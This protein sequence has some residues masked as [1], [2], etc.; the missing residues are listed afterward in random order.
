MA[1]YKQRVKRKSPTMISIIEQGYQS[2]NGLCLKCGT[3]RVM[4]LDA[5]PVT[6]GP[7]DLNKLTLAMLIERIRCK[8][9]GGQMEKVTPW[10]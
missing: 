10:P 1:S 6:P 2:L 8:K 3:W 5:L 9:C 7:I 4:R